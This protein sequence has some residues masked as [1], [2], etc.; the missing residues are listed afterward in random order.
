MPYAAPVALL[1]AALPIL[2]I[3]G[4]VT[5]ASATG[6]FLLLLLMFLI[7]VQV[8]A[9]CLSERLVPSKLYPLL[10]VSVSISLLYHFLLISPNLVGSDINHE[11]YFFSFVNNSGHWNPAYPE[12]DPYNSLLSITILPVILSAVTGV[13][14]VSVFKIIYPLIFSLVPVVLYSAFEP[15]IGKKQA[16]LAVFFFMSYQAYYAD[17]TSIAREQ[18]AEVLVALFL[19]L[20]LKNRLKTLTGKSILLILIFGMIISHYSTAYIIMFFVVISWLI[21]RFRKKATPMPNLPLVFVV[22][23]LLWYVYGSSSASIYS[24]GGFGASVYQGILTQF[25]NPIARPQQV[26]AALGVG[27]LPGPL[28]DLHRLV[29]YSVQFFILVGV[30][31]LWRNRKSRV[32]GDIFLQFTLLALLTLVLSVFLPNFAA[33]LDLSRVYHLTL[34]FLAPACIVGGV[35]VFKWIVRAA[36]G[37]SGGLPALH[38]R[39]LSRHDMSVIFVSVVIVMYFLFNVGFMWEIAGG[40]PTSISLGFNRMRYSDDVSIK[41]G[42]YSA[43]I[44]D[45]DVASARWTSTYVS[46]AFLVC[47]DRTARYHELQSYA[48][49]SLP[50]STPL[51]YPNGEGGAFCSSATSLYTYISYFDGVEHVLTGPTYQSETSHLNVDY[52]L[53]SQNTIYSNGAGF[54]LATP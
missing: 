21:L 48:L 35:V 18:I 31:W 32:F 49:M 36:T 7:A 17:L 46:N 34:L 27:W 20:I 5:A 29:E 6:H 41:A 50:P 53:A 52:L 8:L 40:P 33:G 42:F 54:I 19:M 30:L 10:I 51:L 37:L 44:P 38:V 9:A 3:W 12:S 16:L 15:H 13:D 26:Q 39:R 23:A 47:A 25:S 1:L 28:H 2:A 24:L 43:Y 22:F 14:G 45:E 11:Y 4:A